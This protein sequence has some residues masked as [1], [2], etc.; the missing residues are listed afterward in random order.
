MPENESK[1]NCPACGKIMHKI[2]MPVQNTNLDVCLDGCGGILFNNRE[3]KMFSNPDDDITPLLQAYENKTFKKT[4]DSDLRICPVCGMKMVKN[5]SD[6]KRTVRTDDCYGCG[7][8]FLDYQELETIRFAPTGRRY[9]KRPVLT[10]INYTRENEDETAET[11]AEINKPI[12]DENL[13]NQSSAPVY[14]VNETEMKNSTIKKGALAG[15]ITGFIIS[16]LF[17]D[18]NGIFCSIAKEVGIIN[19]N[20]QVAEINAIIVC[21]IICTLLGI[22]IANYIHNKK[23]NRF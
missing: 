22:F 3:Y 5:Y 16:F 20:R 6:E 18:N 11:F 23:I 12:Y 4:D 21:V 7:A 17:S 19:E 2:Y 14:I 8:R 10:P 13:I 1:I 15:C 9:E